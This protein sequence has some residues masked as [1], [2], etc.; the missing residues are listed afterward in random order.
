[1]RIDRLVDPGSFI[2]SGRFARSI[3]AE[4]RHKTPADGKVAGFAKIDGREIALVSNDFTVLGASSS[5]VNMKKIRHVKGVA[6]SRGMPLVFLGESSGARMPDRMGASGRAILAQDP[7][8]YQR[9]R[10]SPW[11]S[12][13]LGQ[14]YGSSTWYAAMSD[15]VVMR[16]GSVMA[17]ASPNVTSIAIGKPVDPEDLGGWKILTG[18]SGLADLA[19]DT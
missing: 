9:L 5:V 1:E 10:E 13:L 8:E 6:T 16:K 14:C 7:S 19:V 18:V 12:A 4:V 17:V 15:F 2:E 11:A 3:R